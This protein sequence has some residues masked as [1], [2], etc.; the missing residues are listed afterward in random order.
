MIPGNERLKK[1]LI[2]AALDWN[3]QAGSDAF[4]IPVPDTSPPL[5]VAFGTA[6]NILALVGPHPVDGEDEE[7]ADNDKTGA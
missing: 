7:P 4:A 1:H 3:L 6:E 2:Q 5:Y